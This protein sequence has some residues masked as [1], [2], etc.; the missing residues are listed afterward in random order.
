MNFYKRFPLLVFFVSLL[1][2]AGCQFVPDYKKAFLKCKTKADCPAGFFCNAETGLCKTDCTGPNC[3]QDPIKSPC[4]KDTDC[5]D[6][7]GSGYCIDGKCYLGERGDRCE[8][9]EQCWGNTECVVL[10]DQKSYCLLPCREQADCPIE[11]ICRPANVGQKR[12]CV[13]GCDP[14]RQKGCKKGFIC[15]YWEGRGFCALPSGKK[16]EGSI[17]S[18]TSDCELN[19]VC[20]P[21]ADFPHI[22]RC[23]RLCNLNK[24]Y[25]GK[26]FYLCKKLNS[27]SSNVGY[28]EL[29]PRAVSPGD[30]CGGDLLCPN[31]YKCQAP[32]GET[33]KKCVKG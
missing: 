14:V 8:K 9:S 17:C 12:Y 18:D 28:C 6:T 24:K 25:C 13:D 30:R 2:T 7:L 29:T 22:K 10:E 26:D 21:V 1:F 20:R 11:Q 4:K 15:A 33:V 32:P 16:R 27:Q 3:G 19:L 5:S 31:G 23:S